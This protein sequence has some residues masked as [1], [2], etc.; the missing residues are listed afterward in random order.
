MGLQ[1]GDEGKGKIVDYLAS[2][3]DAVAR[4]NG[5]SNAGHTVVIGDRKSTFHLIPSGALKG[6]QLLIGAGVA[7]DPEVLA[8]ELA[9]LP[10]DT[11]GRLLVDSKC[12]LV[13]PVDRDLDAMLERG[14]G[15]AALGTTKRGIGPSYA[16]RALR[17]S[18]RAGDLAVGFD[19]AP[20]VSF[21][22]ALSLD[23]TR[24]DAWA[25]SSRE[26]LR[27]LTGDVAAKVERITGAG[28]SVLYEGSQGTLLDLLHGTYPY[29]T[30][31]HTIA[32]YIPAAL[33]IPPE[34]AGKPLGV[35]K[36]YTT[37][38]GSGPFPSEIG[39]G[40]SER[41]RTLGN[42]YGATTGRPRRVGWLDLVA[43]KYAIRLNG[44]EEVAVTKLDVLSRVDDAKVCAAYKLRGSE[45]TDFQSAMGALGQV[46]PVL[47]SPFSLRGADFEHGLPAEGKRF[48]S[49]IEE[50]LGVRVRLVSHGEERSKT[51]EL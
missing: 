10:G 27:G 41:L 49:F 34:L 9:L 40:D 51:I 31:T 17:L 6:K 12:T 29:V 37:R 28:G 38:V 1:W 16:L 5:G 30:S 21:Y 18:P 48:V 2:G 11:R 47:S 25:A 42:E 45:T 7:A 13:T 43:L 22:S 19:F 35:M 23:R 44:V 46:E 8:Q 24:L 14:R 20:L 26:L 4:F 33:G 39:G 50:E 36:C 15:A 32:S 3:Y